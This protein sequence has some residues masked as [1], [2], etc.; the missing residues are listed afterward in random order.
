MWKIWNSI[1]W[2]NLIRSKTE[3]K[4]NHSI[5]KP[6]TTSIGQQQRYDEIEFWEKG[7]LSIQNWKLI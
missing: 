3:K 4:T 1:V 2:F 5:D 6:Q 7:Q